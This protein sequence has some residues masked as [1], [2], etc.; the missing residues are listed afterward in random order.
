MHSLACANIKI[1]RN[2]PSEFIINLLSQSLQTEELSA[3]F[4]LCLFGHA[5]VSIFR[6][7]IDILLHIFM[8]LQRIKILVV[9]LRRNTTRRLVL[10]KEEQRDTNDRDHGSYD[11][12]K[13]DGLMEQP[14]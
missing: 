12:A 10:Q 5:K 9:G 2:Q 11:I 1:K 8:F 7:L 14:P 3:S 6:E 13:R 4:L